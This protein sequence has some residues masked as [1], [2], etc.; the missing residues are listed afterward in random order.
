MNCNGMATEKNAN[1]CLTKQTTNR[2]I[3]PSLSYR[4]KATV[5]NKAFQNT[6]SKGLGLAYKTA[7]FK[8]MDKL[9]FMFFS[10]CV[11]QTL[12]N[13]CFYDAIFSKLF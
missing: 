1:Q 11:V 6:G 10:R 4:N 5:H 8:T 3:V 9:L 7:V 12:Q 2:T 13:F